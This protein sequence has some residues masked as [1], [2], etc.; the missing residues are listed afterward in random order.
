MVTQTFDDWQRMLAACWVSSYGTADVM[1]TTTEWLDRESARSWRASAVA[2]ALGIDKRRRLEWPTGL[3]DLYIPG[4]R[5]ALRASAVMGSYGW[6]AESW[7]ENRINGYE[8]QNDS[9]LGTL[10]AI[11]T[12][13]P[14]RESAIEHLERLLGREGNGNG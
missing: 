1:P 6:T 3:G 5:G 2:A 8:L 9:G 7:V 4:K 13:H 12:G 11:V 14:T 10:S